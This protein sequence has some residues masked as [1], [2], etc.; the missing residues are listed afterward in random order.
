MGFEVLPLKLSQMGF[1][2]FFA[3]FALVFLIVM[4]LLMKYKPFG[5]WKNSTAMSMIYGVLSF[6]I[7]LFVMLYGLNVY[8]EMFLAWILGRAG[9]IIILL[10][11]ALLIGAFVKGGSDLGE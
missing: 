5:E 4:G 11:M 9:L 2:N 7:A 8:I 6:L 1:F 10:L 3:P